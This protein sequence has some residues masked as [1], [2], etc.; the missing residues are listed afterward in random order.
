VIEKINNDI[1]IT[2]VRKA[3]ISTNLNTLGGGQIN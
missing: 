1:R 2:L 3:Q